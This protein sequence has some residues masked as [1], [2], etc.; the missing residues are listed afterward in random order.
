MDR[1]QWYSE[2]LEWVSEPLPPLT[3]QTMSL[4]HTIITRSCVMVCALLFRRS[5]LRRL[6]IRL[7]TFLSQALLPCLAN[8]P[9]PNA[10]LI[11]IL[12]LDIPAPP[13]VS[14]GRH[15]THFNKVAMETS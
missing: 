10:E 5:S 15:P 2:A 1:Y 6:V 9:K 7:L 11:E 13:E 14:L 8:L 4:L 12:G 3:D